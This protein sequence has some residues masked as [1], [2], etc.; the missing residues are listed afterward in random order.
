MTPE[1]WRELK[2]LF[3]VALGCT[4]KERASYLAE[5]CAG[6]PDLHAEVLA[7]LASH[8]QPG[9]FLSSSPA[10]RAPEA[11]EDS[12]CPTRGRIGPYELLREIGHGG[13]GTVYL[14][15]RADRQPRLKVAIKVI[16]RGM[17]SE[18]VI[19]RFRSERQILA[20]LGHPGIAAFLDGG[21]TD[22]GL[23]YFVMEYVEGEPID[24]HCDARRL[25]TPRRLELFLAVCGA[26]QH[27]HRRL[28]LHRDLKPGNVLVGAD[29]QPKLLDFGLAKLLGTGAAAADQTTPQLR[30][31]TPAFA[32]PE[33]IRGGPI[34]MA[35]DVYSLGALLFLLL[36]GRRA[37]PMSSG[38][39]D[40]LARAA[41]EEEP[42]RPSA[43]VFEPAQ[44]P[45]ADAPV[46]PEAVSALR[47][48]TPDELSR[49]LAGDLDAI[50]LKALRMEPERRYASV[51]EL[52]GDIRCHLRGRPVSALE[53][54][55]P[56]GEGSAPLAKL[57]RPRLP[58]VYAVTRLLA[59]LDRARRAPVAWIAGPA[60]AGKT[61]LVA[62]YLEDRR[63][64]SVWYRVDE[65]DGDIATFFHYMRLAVREADP[66][67][68]LPAF[69]PK[70]GAAIGQ[71]A[72]RFF[73][74]VWERLG[75]RVLVIDNYQDAPPSSPFHDVVQAAL[76][77]I[78][79]GASVLVASRDPPP[80]PL[81]RLAAEGV[82]SV[83]PPS[84]LKLTRRETAA[85]ARARGAK[86]E[87]GE[88]ELLH[89][90]TDG[91]A[92]GVVLILSGGRL[93]GTVR[94]GIQAPSELTEYF[95]SEIFDRLP[96]A[97]RRVLLE[98]ALLPRIPGQLAESLTGYRGA[99]R[100]LHLPDGA[101]GR[102]VRLPSPVPAVPARVR[103]GVTG[104][105]AAPAGPERGSAGS[106]SGGR[107]RRCG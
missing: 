69:T 31:L 63:I 2:E 92:A 3:G 46:A 102:R 48:A 25:A 5:A 96:E 81:A 42:P 6:D 99:R 18:F 30:F 24:V 82:V 68:Q 78:P 80:A 98:T 86:L 17:G 50:V 45:D 19:S 104:A 4:G 72:R 7:L 40:E 106:G 94:P 91:W 100:V 64:P 83:V 14:G 101:S 47:G 27:A 34:T 73:R 54:S 8:D 41:C 105:G 85:L 22:D 89:R 44:G 97:S 55:K 29:G 21:N 28:V 26:V 16:R 57:S 13:M 39:F 43:V 23:P 56:T 38:S 61:T 66:R 49:S 71:F 88:A 10:E 1:R 77:E 35:S 51:G 36:T 67:A 74:A 58:A 76:S 32:S 95:A 62:A 20:S 65:G 37:Y 93:D 70:Y 79:R 33:Q 12:R 11:A 59:R 84:E 60:G 9:G 90:S 103:R 107:R 15:A 52:A 53:R 87:A 75:R